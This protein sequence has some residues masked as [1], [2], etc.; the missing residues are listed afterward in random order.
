M[1]NIA[2]TLTPDEIALAYDS[3]AAEAL[4]EGAAKI[5]WKSVA[6]SR[7]IRGLPV[8]DEVSGLIARHSRRQT[9]ALEVLA[10]LRPNCEDSP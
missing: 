1:S 10:K 2:I 5:G 9:L 7:E 6:E 8:S 4:S 3:V